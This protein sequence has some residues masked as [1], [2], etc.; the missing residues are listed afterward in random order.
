MNETILNQYEISITPYLSE[1]SYG[2]R[3][4]V[5]NAEK[6]EYIEILEFRTKEEAEEYVE[7]L[8]G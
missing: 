7:E 8:R 3:V 6:D 2:Y 1:V 5:Y 4:T